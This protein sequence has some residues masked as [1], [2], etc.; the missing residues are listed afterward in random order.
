MWQFPNDLSYSR[1]RL[2]LYKPDL[3]TRSLS[4]LPVD[5][6]HDQYIEFT[7]SDFD[8]DAAQSTVP[9]IDIQPLEPSKGKI[10]CDTN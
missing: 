10:L 5:S 1:V 8:A 3:P 4:P 6:Q 9:F 7:H 2:D